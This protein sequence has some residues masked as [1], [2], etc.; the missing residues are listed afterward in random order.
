MI[1]NAGQPSKFYRNHVALDAPAIDDESFRP[2]WR[3]RT[4]LDQLLLDRAIS[5]V[6]WRAAA[7]FRSLGEIVLAEAWQT[8]WLDQRAS[9]FDY[10]MALA[11][12]ADA[13][14]RLRDIR[15]DLGDFAF[16]LL[17]AHLVDNETWTALGRRYRVHP[18]TVRSWTI[19]ALKALAAVIWKGKV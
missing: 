9:G 6:V 2:Y 19:V 1:D 13:L 5:V 4:R 11:R 8:R 18:K 10:G 15:R 14:D 16:D 3:V 12:R 7:S 17:E